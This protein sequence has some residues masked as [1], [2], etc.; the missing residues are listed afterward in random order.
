MVS[1]IKLSLDGSALVVNQR[2]VHALCHFCGDAAP[3]DIPFKSPFNNSV[4]YSKPKKWALIGGGTK[5]Q[6]KRFFICKYCAEVICKTSNTFVP[7]K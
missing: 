3:F 2:E 5:R 6:P 1:D 4:F 7:C